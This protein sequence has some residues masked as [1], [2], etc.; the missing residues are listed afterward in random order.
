LDGS[1]DIIESLLTEGLELQILSIPRVLKT[2]Q[3]IPVPEPHP[4]ILQGV[5]VLAVAG[6]GRLRR[7]R[8]EWP[9]QS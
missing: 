8:Q 2:L 6:L 3:A 5:E 9:A 4:L 7:K 1:V